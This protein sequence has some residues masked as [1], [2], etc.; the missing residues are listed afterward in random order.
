MTILASLFSGDSIASSLFCLP[1]HPEMAPPTSDLLPL[2]GPSWLSTSSQGTGLVPIMPHTLSSP[3]QA[4]ELSPP[5]DNSTL[6]PPG[7][8]FHLIALQCVDTLSIEM[9]LGPLM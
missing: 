9:L 1:C 4:T 7:A 5:E 8:H 3:I 2:P 6:C